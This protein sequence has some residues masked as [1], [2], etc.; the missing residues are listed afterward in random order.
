MADKNKKK[1]QREPVGDKRNEDRGARQGRAAT[2]VARAG[3]AG[4]RTTGTGRAQGRVGT[5]TRTQGR[6]GATTRA[7]PGAQRGQQGNEALVR[8]LYDAFN[9]RDFDRWLES[10]TR[11]IEIVNVATGETFRGTEGQRQ[12]QQN[13]AAAFPD[14]RAEI[15]KVIDGGDSVAVEFTGRGTHSGPLRGPAG[16]IA[17]TNRRAAVSF[18]DVHEIRG[19]K[20]A[21][22][23]TYF[24]AA[25]MMRQL[26]LTA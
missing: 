12:Y 1:R 22:T 8:A 9:D 2:P 16:E 15:T 20:I 23:R 10:V 14:G 19:G 4:T 11:D 18:C 7:A 6:A 25:T 5:T 3:R 26:G 13:W 17:P 24:D 21:R